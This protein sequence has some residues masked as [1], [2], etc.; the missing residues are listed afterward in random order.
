[1]GVGLLVRSEDEC[2]RDQNQSA[3]GRV[4]AEAPRQRQA[5]DPE[6]VAYDIT[7]AAGREPSA[8]SISGPRGLPT[9]DTR[10]KPSPV[11]YNKP[12]LSIQDSVPPVG[13]RTRPFLFLK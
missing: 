13:F 5:M 4:T 3:V 10:H 9:A 11:L 12:R 1:M 7:G 6:K 2:G 8:G